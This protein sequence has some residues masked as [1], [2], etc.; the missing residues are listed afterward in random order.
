[1]VEEMPKR[2]VVR[3]L[4]LMVAHSHDA[5]LCMRNFFKSLTDRAYN[6]YVNLKIGST[7]D[8]EH[9]FSLFNT[10]VLYTIVKFTL[11]SEECVSMQR[12]SW[13]HM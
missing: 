6:W 3:F 11:A 7:H 8:Q 9:L 1:M 13:M 4:D 10:K 2:H 5:H 12:R